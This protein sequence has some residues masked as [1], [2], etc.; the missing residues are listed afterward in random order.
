MAKKKLPLPKPKRFKAGKPPK[1]KMID[2]NGPEGNAL[3]LLALAKDYC[4]ELELNYNPIYEELTAG[5]YENLL[6]VFRK[7]FDEFVTLYKY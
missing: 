5:D 4:K 2:L 3:V 6:T 1:K 7:Y